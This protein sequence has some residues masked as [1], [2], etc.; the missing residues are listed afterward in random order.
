MRR[1]TS[2][3]LLMLFFSATVFSQQASTGLAKGT[4]TGDPMKEQVKMQQVEQ[5]MPI[6]DVADHRTT[7]VSDA[8]GDIVYTLDLETICGDNQLLG[9]AYANGHFWVTGA[10][11]SAN[12]NYIYEVDPVAGTLVNSYEQGTT[13]DWGMRDLVWVEA[14]GLLYAGDDN[15]FYSIDPTDGTVTT[16]FSPTGMGVIRALAYDGTNFWT[17][18]FGASLYEFSIDGTI[19]NTYNPAVAAATYGAAYDDNEGFLYL[20]SQDDAMFYQFDLMGNHTGVTY[21]VSAAQPAGI[22][23]G[24]FFD[25]GNLVPGFATLG[26]LLQGTP[27]IVG[28]MELYPTVIYP[29]DV[30]ISAINQPTSGVDLTSAEPIQITIKNFGTATQSDIPWELTWNGPVRETFNG[31]YP[32]PLAEG[33]TALIDVGTADLSAYGSYSFEACTQLVGDEFPD[34]DCKAKTVVNSF[35]EYCDASTTTEDEYIANVLCGDIDNSS[36]WQGGVADYTD[37]STAIPAGDSEPITVTNGNPWASDI[38]YCWVDWNMNYE[39][40]QGGDE[41]F[42]LTSDGTGLTFTGAISPP[43]G[44]PEGDYRMRVRMTYFTPPVPCGNASYGEVEDYTITVGQGAAADVGVQSIDIAGFVEPGTIAMAATVKNFGSETQTFDVTL[45]DEVT[46]YSSTQTVTDLVSGESFQVAFDDWTAVTG[47]YNF[48]AC[49]ELA[50]DEK[51]NNDCKT[52]QVIVQDAMMVYAYNAYDPSGALVEGPVSFD[53]G[54]PGF[55]NQL[56]PTTSTDFIAGACWAPGGIWY[57]SQYGGGIYE[58]NPT[59]GDMTFIGGTGDFSGIAHDGV[60]MYGATI[61]ELYEVDPITG[62]ATLIGPMNNPGAV[63]IAIACNAAGE[64][65]GFDI[66]D[67]VFYSIDK[68]TGAATAIGPL[69]FDFNYAQDMSFDKNLDVCYLSGYTTTGGL[70]SV[71]VATGAATFIAAFQGGAEI[72]G[73]AIPYEYQAF[74]NDLGVVSILEPVTGY[75]LTNA[76]PVT[77]RVRNYGE[78]AQTDF[79]VWYSINGGTPVMET[80]AETIEP[81]EN[82]DYTFTATADL[83]AYDN[84]IFDACTDLAGDQNPS[85]D[86]KQVAVMNLQYGSISGSTRD[87][88]NNSVTDVLIELGPYSALSIGS[89]IGAFYNIQ[90]VEAGTYDLVASKEGY[91]TKVYP[92][93]VI[94]NGLNTTQNVILEPDLPQP[95]PFMEEWAGG[96]FDDNLWGFEPSQGNWVISATTGNPAPTARFNWSPS[97]T[98]YSHTL[99]SR[100]LTTEA[101]SS[102][103]VLLEYDLYLSNYS[104]ETVEG[105]EVEVFAG[106]SW[107][108]VASYDNQ[109]G[110]I[111]W[112]SFSHDI[113]SLVSGKGIFKVA[114]TA[115]GANSFNINQ[116]EMD[117]IHVYETEFVNFSGTITAL[118]TGDPIEGASINLE[119]VRY[120]VQTGPDGTYSIDIQAGTYDVTLTAEGYNT[121]TAEGIEILDD[122]VWDVAM[123]APTMEVTPLEFVE[124]LEAGETADYDIL[125]NNAGDGQLEWKAVIIDNSKGRSTTPIG[126]YAEPTMVQAGSDE[127]KTYDNAPVTG[128]VNVPLA[129]DRS[130]L[131]DNGPLETGFC[132]TTGDPESMIQPPHTA[133]GINFNQ[134]AGWSAGDDFTIPAG[135]DWQIESF[136]FFGYQTSAGNVSTLTGAFV[137]IWDGDP[138]NGGSPIWGDQV[139]NLFAS[140]E[141]TGMYRVSQTG[142]CNTD[143]AIH[144]VVA[145]TPG[146]TLSPGTYWVEFSTTGTAASGPWVPLVSEVGVA[147]DGNGLQNNTSGVWSQYLSGGVGVEWPFIINGS[148]GDAWI[149]LSATE[150]TLEPGKANETIVMTL[151]TASLT[152]GETYFADIIFTSTPNVGTQTVSVELFVDGDLGMLTGFVFDPLTRGPVQGVSITADELRGTFSTTTDETGY[153]EINLPIGY[154]DVTA[155]K[156]NYL[157]AMADSILIELDLI[158]NQDFTLGFEP[159]VMTYAEADYFSVDLGWDGNPILNE[160]G[161]VER[162][163]Y[164]LSN[165]TTEPRVAQPEPEHGPTVIVPKATSSRATGDDCVDPIVIPGFP[166]TDVNTTCGRGNN[167][168]ET[169]LGYYDGGEDIVYQFTLTE[170]TKIGI[171]LATTATWTGVLVTSECPIAMDCETFITGSSGPKYLEATLDAGTYYIMIDTWPT[172]D[173]IPEFTLTIEVIEECVVECPAGAIQEGELCG[174][175][176]NGGCNSD[177]PMFE[178]IMDGDVVCGTAWA[179]TASRDTDWYE[180]VLDAPKTI[181]WSVEAEFPVFAFIIDGNFGCEGSYIISLAQGDT[182]GSIAVATAT[183]PPGTYWLWVGNQDFYDYPCGIENDY[184]AAVTLDD[185]DL[186]YFNIYRNGEWLAETY[187]EFYLDED[188]EGGEEYC[189]SVSQVFPGGET[190]M[191]DELCAEVLNLPIIAVDPVALDMAVLP[192]G[193]A[194][195]VLTVMNQGDG[196]LDF[197]VQLVF[198]KS[199]VASTFNP[200]ANNDPAASLKGSQTEP[201]DEGIECPEGSIISQPAVDFATAYTADEDAGYSAYQSFTGGGDLGGLRFWTISAFFDGVDW[202]ACDG[203][204]PRPFT[205]AFYNDDAGQPGA[206]IDEFVLDLNRVNTGILFAGAYPVYEYTADFPSTV[207]LTAGWFSVQSMVGTA[208]NCWNLLLNQPGGLGQCLQFDGVTY[209]AQPDPLGFCLIGET[210]TP[211]LSVTPLSGSIDGMGELPLQVL[212]NAADLE[213]GMYYAD[214]VISSN[215]PFTPTIT[216]PVELQVGGDFGTIAGYVTDM[217]DAKGPVQGVSITADELRASYSTT[218]DAE[219]YYELNVP[220]GSYNVTAAKAGYQPQTVEGVMVVVDVTTPLDFVLEIA[221]PTLL[222]ANGG[223]AQIDLGWEPNPLF[224][225]RDAAAANISFGANQPEEKFVKDDEERLH[226][227][228]VIVPKATSSRA[229]GD[230][231]VDPIV[232]GE[233][234]YTDVNTT[235]GRGNN[236]METC[237][238]SYDGGEDIVYQFT[239]TEASGIAISM[240][241]TSTW[242]GVLV[243]SECPIGS[244]CEAFITGSSGNKELEVSLLPGTYYIML[245][246]WPTPNCI[247]EFTIVIDT[248][249]Y[250]GPEPGD[251]CEDPLEYGSVNDDPIVGFTDP[252]QITWYSFTAD[253]DFGSV[254]VSLC[255]STFDTKLEVWYNCDDASYAFYNDDFCGLQS[256][257][258]TGAMAAGATWYAKVYG[259]SATSTGEYTLTITGAEPCTVE[260]PPDAIQEAEACGEDLNGG[261]NADVPMFES[262]QCGDVVCGTAWADSASRDTDWYELII[263]DDPK[264]ITWS[265]TAE[266]PVY[267]FIIDGNFGCEGSYI[268]EIGEAVACDTAIASATLAPGT[269]WLWVGAQVFEGY[270]CG[271][272]NNYVA[273]LTCEEAWLPYY[274]VFRDG[275]EIAKSYTTT[276]TD[277]DVEADTEYCYTVTQVPQQGFETPESNELCAM[278]LCE[279]G[280][281]YTMVFN[282]SYGDGWNGAFVSFV[283]DGSVLGSF[284]LGDGSFGT[285]VVELCDGYE[286]SLV[287]TAGAYDSECGFELYDPDGNL[288]YSFVAGG[289]PAAGEFFNFM[290]ECPGLPEQLVVMAEGWNAWSSYINPDARMGMDDLMDPILEDMIVTQY[291]T[292]LFYPEYDINTMGAFSNNHGYLSKMSAEAT[293]PVVGMMADPTVEI[294]AGWNLFPVLQ[295]CPVAAADVFGGM[296][297]FVIA[298]DL[299]G[300]GIYYPAG[301]L[302]TLQT[303]MP[304]KAYWVKVDEAG[305]YTYPGCDEKSAVIG[306]GASIRAA[307]ATPWNDVNYTPVNHAVIFDAEAVATLENGDLIG[308]FTA[309]G[310]LAG[311]AEV[312]G[313]AMGLQ[314]YADDFVT[315]GKDGFAEGEPV[316][317]RLY[318]PATSEEFDIEV[319]YS[320]EAP[321]ATGLFEINGVSIV[322]DLKASP[323]SVGAS[324][325]DG[326]NIYPN[327]STGV[328]NIAVG[329]LDENV[330]FVV[331]NAQGQEVYSGSLIESQILDLSTEPKGVYFIKFINNDVLGVEKLIIK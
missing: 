244:N 103:V 90:G 61:T 262:I 180:I 318:R 55:I 300:N 56:A 76:E 186:S 280:C 102:E 66:V 185:A 240:T 311:L 243:T 249:E 152:I 101:K 170:L 277:T 62:D 324:L 232:I 272:F 113:T 3:L 37:Q 178:S 250:Q 248:Y 309:E 105:M 226:G 206:M 252:G 11:N 266:F 147:P 282:D 80:V 195:D 276:Y 8:L 164:S 40:E 230:D 217:L 301:E 64:L 207:S 328:F 92:G 224:A 220:V 70:Y 296:A 247:D 196:L 94:Q 214:I 129:G 54:T 84:Y 4:P 294:V 259:F 158:T 234:P 190:G 169:C 210:T 228:T 128:G 96:N 69:G 215:D 315:E 268:M 15:G 264:T 33:E 115:Y 121:V 143:R 155:E 194:T 320:F 283:Q 173:C 271:T 286:T 132:A 218:T 261:C 329:N 265:V 141:W 86:C 27:D 41:E 77:V 31:T 28:A 203:I 140:T 330:K 212:Y 125:V 13:T 73:F 254:D 302:Y 25:F 135:S 193:N 137:T 260:C 325:M 200:P 74:D 323:T 46:R 104:L 39:F 285:D 53:L 242:T 219:G 238:G 245:D 14:D 63:M 95:I 166:Y 50:G 38:V 110:S 168:E 146:L 116:W 98:D 19:V 112:T 117:N 161:M 297:G 72:T 256:Q 199:A 81:G 49:T 78:V 172:P 198:A 298:W 208:V 108:T 191:S 59:N 233:F 237:L 310:M 257:I 239:L 305:S 93:I 184:V 16:V 308:A 192:G 127:A 221:G 189:Y 88:D 24:A 306:N 22:A 134:A 160:V 20:F 89:P 307:N 163:Q 287:W 174:E 235:C 331:M 91:F 148:A 157:P 290:S 269:Y 107:T 43:A 273:E 123:T 229:T 145:A 188:V 279:A 23:G 179:D 295:E 216:V 142:S 120:D 197:D 5:Q 201:T 52:K 109:G 7:V 293:L 26:F 177:V 281:E 175:D 57:G 12:P 131:Y 130:V 153:Y 258:T 292:E 222:Y 111:P 10:G 45:T 246:T 97:T 100:S 48:T 275:D 211:W 17:K 119:G 151:N 68:A 136:E 51:P 29:N 291:F 251:N 58:I 313:Q 65:F 227:P 223:V 270:P 181:T 114:F 138:M 156:E 82:Y 317:F 209:T 236:Y 171:D 144:K 32:G 319:T 18:S 9:V 263:L 225:M 83:S 183:V 159:P 6:A 204:D 34:N 267:A 304:G 187:Y 47:T 42:I 118:A 126:A 231:C 1:I 60:T 44:T 205:I 255:G 284:T 79:D 21:D 36:G 182:C 2:M 106:G 303:L 99:V 154:Y 85:N 274:N 162:G 124:T 30:G 312:N 176:L 299:L 202:V 167:Y 75:Q 165:K 289:A 314:L 316:S 241:T 322:T 321:N 139:T 133:F 213:V 150:G 278:M 35:P 327:P 253:D 87:I 71:D 122:F 67:D 288:L 149:S 326:L